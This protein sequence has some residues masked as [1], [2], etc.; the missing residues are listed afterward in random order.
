MFRNFDK[1][2]E[3]HISN[4]TSKYDSDFYLSFWDMQGIGNFRNRLDYGNDTINNEIKSQIEKN[5]KPK[6]LEFQNFQPFNEDFDIIEKKLK[7]D[8]NPPF[9]KNVLSMYYKIKRCSDMVSKSGIDYDIVVRL[10]PDI[11]FNSSMRLEN[12]KENSLYV[13][14]DGNWGDAYNDQFFYGDQKTMKI[15]SNVYD[16]LYKI[17]ETTGIHQSPEGILWTFLKQKEINVSKVVMDYDLIRH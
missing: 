12:P 6:F 1:N 10:R 8:F 7:P 9:M 14:N 11:Y 3:N 17:W 4:L 16:N 13:N 2:L 15:V 5:L